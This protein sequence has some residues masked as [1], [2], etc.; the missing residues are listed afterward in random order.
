MVASRN[1]DGVQIIQLDH[2]A[3]TTPLPN[4]ISSSNAN[5][6]SYARTGDTITVQ[7]N[8][9]SDINSYHVSIL[10]PAIN[11]TVNHNGSSLNA[12]VNVPFNSALGDATFNITISNSLSSLVVTENDLTS[13]NVFIGDTSLIANATITSN[14]A[15]AL[16]AKSNDVISILQCG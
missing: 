6:S 12:S 15:N 14:N 2:P 8:A 9:N 13:D 4:L 3:T 10:D 1:G 11:P 16:F 5:S 7:I